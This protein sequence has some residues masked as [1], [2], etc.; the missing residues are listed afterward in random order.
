MVTEHKDGGYTLDG[1]EIGM[2]LTVVAVVQIPFQV[3]KKILLFFHAVI[4][5]KKTHTALLLSNCC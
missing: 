3:S 5:K 4:K 2:I 1:N